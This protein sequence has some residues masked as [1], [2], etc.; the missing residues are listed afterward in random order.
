M[1]RRPRNTE[2]GSRVALRKRQQERKYAV[3]L[4]AHIDAPDHS[5]AVIARAH[6]LCPREVQRRWRRYQAAVS[7]AAPSPL[8]SA[9]TD[10]RGGHNRAFTVAQEQ[11]L[12]DTVLAA[13]PAMTHTAIVDAALALKRDVAVAAHGVARATRSAIVFKAS[14]R[15]VTQFK[16]RNRL[17]SHRTTIKWVSGSTADPTENEHRILEY[18]R[19]ARDAID[20]Y[21]AR[22]VL[23][24][25]E[26]PVAKC[27]NPITGVVETGSGRAAQCRT[28][29]GNRLNVTHFPCISAAGD[30]LQMCAIIKGKTERT[31]KKVR[32]GASP[33]VARVRLYYSA[34]GWINSGIIVRWLDDVV[35]PYLGGSPGAL[36]LD[37]YQA[38][39][40]DEVV[41]AAAR[42][43]I[44]LIKVPP[45]LTSEYQPLDV[46]FNGPMTKARQAIW[47]KRRLTFPETKDSHQEAVH[48]AQV[49]YDGISRASTI[50]AWRAA[51]LVD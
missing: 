37:D 21:G 6:G 17:S 12:R 46:K 26:T 22:H 27:E 41:A 14:S 33:A 35:A 8:V 36:L 38:H 29:A 43:R 40:T 49:A 44:E 32:E 25:D 7:D 42:L 24:M 2:R 51:F 15:F 13:S 48:R 3:A 31:L 28:D 45:G 18:V 9:T 19:A 34:S 50:D 1:G 10:R 11:I 20:R 5:L 4:Q 16:R 23:N 30:K 39:W 47:I